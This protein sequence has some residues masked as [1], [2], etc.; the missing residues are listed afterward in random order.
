MSE[1]ERKKTIFD[2]SK[3][4]IKFS[5]WILYTGLDRLSPL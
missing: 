5:T 4:L 2:L 1:R 3:I